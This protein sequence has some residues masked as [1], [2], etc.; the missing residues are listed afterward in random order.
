MLSDFLIDYV[1]LTQIQ[2]YIPVNKIFKLSE[3]RI[4]STIVQERFKYRQENENRTRIYLLK[5]IFNHTYCKIIVKNNI[6]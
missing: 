4:Y 3:N 5:E 2:V 1:D 6:S